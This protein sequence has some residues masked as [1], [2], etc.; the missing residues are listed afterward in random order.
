MAIPM[1]DDLDLGKVSKLLGALLEQGNT[2]TINAALTA[3]GQI[4]Y[5]TTLLRAKVFDGTTSQIVLQR[6]DIDTDSSFASP[7]NT[8]VPSTQAVVT[9]IGNLLAGGTR[10]RG[11]VTMTAAS[12]Y[13][14]AEAINYVNGT[15][16]GD[17]SGAGPSIKVG[18]AWYIGNSASFQMGPTADNK[19]EKGD[20]VI[21][22]TDGATNL[23][24]EWLVLDAD[25]KEA[26]TTTLG[27]VLLATLA[28][29][30]GNAGLDADKAITVAILNSFL[31]NPESGDAA[32]AYYRTTKITQTLNNGANTITHGKNT[33]DISN[34]RFQNATTF[35]YV[36][37]GWTASTL[38]TITATRTAGTA[39]FN[40][41]ITYRVA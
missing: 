40:I 33:R 2:T 5:D 9:Y 6:N 11:S 28:Q 22:L 8:T 21:A 13:P 29:V 41:F 30:Q 35:E 36:E 26:T 16:V 15:Q 12:T 27:L 38:T 7:S 24:A 10:I 1:H 34:V 17:G 37:M 4:G 18:D 23:D 19:V 20:L 25:T 32:A 14:V 31:N 39:S 3:L